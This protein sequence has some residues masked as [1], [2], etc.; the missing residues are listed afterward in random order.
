MTT[1]ATVVDFLKQ[2]APTDLAADWD[3]VGLLLGDTAAPVQRVMTCLTLSPDVAA[4]AVE[5]GVQLIV[6]H[7]PILFR[8]VK[9]L[10]TATPEGRTLL[11]LIRGGVAVYSPHTALD[12]TAGGINDL[13]SRR[14]NLV[15]VGP[16]RRRE[17]PRQ[18]K[19]VVF[20]PDKDLTR[21]SDALFAAGAGQIGQYSECSFRLS[22][23]GTFFG[24]DA[25][26]PTVGQKGRR[27][28]VSEWRLEAVCPETA[29]E[30]A[31][32]AMRR[33]HSYEEPA[34][35]VYSLRPARSPLGEGRVGRLPRPIPLAE[36]AET[37]K[38]ALAAKCVQTVGEL[39]RS[40]E[41][42]AIV[43]GAG[44]EM[45]SDAVRA[46]ADVFLTGEMRFHDYLTALAQGVA[47]V[48]PGHYATERCGI[49]ELAALL[50]AKWA[51]LEVWAS[52]RERD[53]IN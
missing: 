9:R 23:T 20:V 36:F 14:L 27:E 19:I 26:N 53:P 15:E 25:T 17:G 1:V 40:V 46:R 32:T 52:R 13:L 18:C 48:L 22:G 45:F 33:A 42:I 21:V 47:L 30:Q 7:H 37:V 49:E 38:T 41:R 10:T 34:Y 16:L 28:E 8:A 31:V 11:A 6:T 50:Q 24:S 3:N 39:T 44:G 5:S 29:V 35:D 43:C 2:F 51:D 4:E 12:N